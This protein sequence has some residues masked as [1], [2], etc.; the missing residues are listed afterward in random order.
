MVIRICWNRFIE[1]HNNNCLSDMVIK[2]YQFKYLKG[3]NNHFIDSMDI[4]NYYFQFDVVNICGIDNSIDIIID[5][6]K[7][8]I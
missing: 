8:K 5:Q 6:K 1:E 3:Y 7:L 2:I 4:R